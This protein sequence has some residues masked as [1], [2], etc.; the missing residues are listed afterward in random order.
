MK[1]NRKIPSST[2]G[3]DNLTILFKICSNVFYL[4]IAQITLRVLVK[5]ILAFT[6]TSISK[7]LVFC[8]QSCIKKILGANIFSTRTFIVTRSPDRLYFQDPEPEMLT[9]WPLVT[10]RYSNVDVLKRRSKRVCHLLRFELSIFWSITK[11]LMTSA[12]R[13]GS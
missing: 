8:H 1:E 6:N 3:L 7:V 2:S 9:H 13:F 12:P 11:C 5:E 10:V 4:G